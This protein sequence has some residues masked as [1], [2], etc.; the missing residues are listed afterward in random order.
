MAGWFP[1][2]FV[3]GLSMYALYTVGTGRKD[4]ATGD[5]LLNENEFDANVQYRFQNEW[6]KGLSLR[7]RYGTVQ[8]SGGDRIHQAR[9][10]LNYDLPF[11]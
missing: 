8:E 1:T 11:L 4:S 2:P 3:D 10:L 9:A 7:F 5:T 6:L